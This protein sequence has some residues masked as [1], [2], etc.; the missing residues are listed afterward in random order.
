MQYNPNPDGSEG[1]GIKNSNF[2]H[3]MTWLSC[4]HVSPV[5]ISCRVVRP[6]TMHGPN[7]KTWGCLLIS[8]VA[9][10]N[11]WG[12][13][14]H[15]VDPDIC[16]LGS[17]LLFISLWYR[18]IIESNTFSP[19]VLTNSQTDIKNDH[20]R[21]MSLPLFMRIA[22]W[23]VQLLQSSNTILPIHKQF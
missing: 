14:K 16:F 4:I 7:D 1:H 12:N 19:I 21:S 5:F 13:I 18:D 22:V 10:R 6:P 15:E 23:W 9:H 3:C 2:G 8:V 11:Y 17:V 20:G